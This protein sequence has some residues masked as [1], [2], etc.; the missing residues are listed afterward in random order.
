MLLSADPKICY[1]SLSFILTLLFPLT[2]LSCFPFSEILFSEGPPPDPFNNPK[3]ICRNFSSTFLW[4]QLLTG[5][6]TMA[7]IPLF[8]QL[9]IL[10]LRQG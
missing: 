4:L 3:A 8:P 2:F 7:V 1:H 5:P 6:I 10:I 9:H